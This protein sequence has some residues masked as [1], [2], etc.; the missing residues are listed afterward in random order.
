[1]PPRVRA[2]QE[3]NRESIDEGA[4]Q[5]QPESEPFGA[6]DAPQADGTDGVVQSKADQ[7]PP[8]AQGLVCDRGGA[9]G[10]GRPRRERCINL[11]RRRSHR[12]DSIELRDSG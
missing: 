9:A 10:V 11:K 1:M 12:P 4:N 8:P 2:G 6:D 3:P 7:K 5:G